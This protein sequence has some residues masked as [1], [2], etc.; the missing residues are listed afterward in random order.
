MRA[1]ANPILTAGL[2][3]AVVITVVATASPAGAHARF[4]GAP[5][6]FPVGTDQNLSLEVPHERDDATFNTEVKI[7][8]GEGWQPLACT[9]KPTWTCSIGAEAG[10]DVVHFIKDPG[11]GPAED[12]TFQFRVRTAS[13]VGT[14][15]FPTIQIYNTGEEVAW[16]GGSGSTE[17]APVLKTSPPGGTT[18]TTSPTTSPPHTTP[19]TTKGPTGTTAPTTA[20][21]GPGGADPGSPGDPNTPTTIG[22]P[23]TPDGSGASTTSVVGATTTSIDGIT[24][25]TSATATEATDA[26]GRSVT[27]AT[28][29]ARG[30]EEGAALE[31][32]AS[33]DGTDGSG[34]VPAALVL[35]VLIALAGGGYLAYRRLGP[36]SASDSSADDAAQHDA[37]T[38]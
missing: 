31:N 37:P 28:D 38:T 15:P 34:G 2:V 26:Q 8:V 11:A 23:G 20:G 18:E 24:S 19:P 16:I 9:E 22:G 3:A 14:Y 13:T 6:S 29:D 21:S 4:V 36:S 5:A 7:A 10:R 32:A 17:P 12:E 1:R 33:T 30:T 35:I 27:G 25:S